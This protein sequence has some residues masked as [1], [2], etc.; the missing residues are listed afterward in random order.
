MEV[1][2]FSVLVSF[3]TNAVKSIRHSKLVFSDAQTASE[4]EPLIAGLPHTRTENVI[5]L[6]MVNDI[7][8]WRGCDEKGSILG[9]AIGDP[10]GATIGEDTT[11]WEL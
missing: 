9:I 8:L 11:E 4:F 3:D 7:S 1:K 6:S 2:S 5:D 10:L